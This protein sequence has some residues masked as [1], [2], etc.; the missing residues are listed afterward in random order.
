MIIRGDFG[1]FLAE[2]EADGFTV[3]NWYHRQFLQVA[4]TTFVCPSKVYAQKLHGMLADY[5]AGTWYGQAKPLELFKRK[6]GSYPNAQRQV[7]FTLL[8]F[9]LDTTF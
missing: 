4:Q 3:Y 8:Y 7:S 2:R 1:E 5:F 9:N 6:K